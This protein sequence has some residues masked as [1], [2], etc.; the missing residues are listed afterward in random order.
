M[1][2]YTTPE[3]CE[4]PDVHDTIIL[5][6]H[7]DSGSQTN[8]HQT[9]HTNIPSCKSYGCFFHRFL[10]LAIYLFISYFLYTLKGTGIPHGRCSGKAFD[11]RGR[12]SICSKRTQFASSK[13]NLL[14]SVPAPA[15][16]LGFSVNSH[17]KGPF[18]C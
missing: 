2:I 5:R 1:G 15:S 8:P 7:P 11:E 12:S 9:I 17:L 16:L 10:F 3:R 6:S 14:A 18:L 4:I 13:T